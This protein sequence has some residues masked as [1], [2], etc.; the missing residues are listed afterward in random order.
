MIP[1]LLDKKAGSL[2]FP[3]SGGRE[4]K[5]KIL[6]HGQGVEKNEHVRMIR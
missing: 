3:V 1:Q 6:L 5:E 4:N 2:N